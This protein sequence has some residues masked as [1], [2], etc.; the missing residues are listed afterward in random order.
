M[1]KKVVVG[2]L[3][4]CMAILLILGA[5]AGVVPAETF[6]SENGFSETDIVLVSLDGED[7]VASIDSDGIDILESYPD[8]VLAEIS[9]QRKLELIEEGH[10]IE[11][12]ENRHHVGLQS[13]SFNT[14][15][16]EPDIPESLEIDE[17]PDDESGYYIVQFIGPISSEWKEE[18]RDMDV[19]FHEFRHNFNFIVEM[20]PETKENVEEK[21]FVNWAGIYQPA[22]RFDNELLDEEETLEL[23]V[24]TFDN[25]ES[26]TT[27]NK[28][29]NFAESEV[30]FV[31]ENEMNVEVEPK[32]I[33]SLANLKEVK[34]IE[35]GGFE[36]EFFNDDATWVTQTNEQ[37]NRK[38]TDQG[39]TG[40]GQLLTVC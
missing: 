31:G 10:S 7:D 29:M 6:E 33:E 30:L 4:L 20:D 40:D 1:Q 17:Y 8:S 15:E 23:E 11:P 25:S 16:G 18:L 2:L 19:I 35:R 3:S 36:R 9:E 14:D 39:V 13:H 28:V 37:N 34:S 32:N 38:V 26:L 5:F 12:L 21:D 22:Y 27:A 24:S